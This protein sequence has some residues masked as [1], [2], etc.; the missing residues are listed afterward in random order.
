MSRFARNVDRN[1]VEVVAALRKVGCF[2]QHLHTVGGG[3]PDLLAGRCGRWVLLEV[4]DW[5]KPPSARALTPAEASWHK[6]ASMMGL[7]AYVVTTTTEALAA[8]GVAAG[9]GVNSRE[10]AQPA[11]MVQSAKRRNGEARRA[12][13]S[14]SG[15]GVEND[16]AD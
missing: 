5:R 7:P 8:V 10:S 11:E 2:V 4:K 16:S 13:L 14:D 9:T 12:V 6:L 15:G 1:Q 3:C